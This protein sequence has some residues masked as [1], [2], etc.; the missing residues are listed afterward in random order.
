MLKKT[1]SNADDSKYT[2]QTILFPDNRYNIRDVL[3]WLI[4]NKL[5]YI[6]ITHEGNYYR[7]RQAEPSRNVKYFSKKRNDGVVLVYMYS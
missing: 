1:S 2:L 6:K 7:A 3:K 4:D 5:R